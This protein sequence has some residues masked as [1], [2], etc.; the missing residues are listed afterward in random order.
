M[1]S[2]CHRAW[3]LVVCSLC[4]CATTK[5]SPD[6][7]RVDEL[8]LEGPKA[9]KEETITDRIVTNATPW[10][11][12]WFPFVGGTEWF[13]TNTWQAD[14]RRI[15]RLYEAHGYYQARIL[16][17]TVT[18]T[19]KGSVRI[20]VKLTEGAPAKLASLR[21][22]G[23]DGLPDQRARFEAKSPL[24]LGITFLEDDWAKAKSL[25]LENLHEA[26]YA[27]AKVVGEAQVDLDG[28]KVDATLS[29]E[30]GLRYTFGPIYAP[31]IG[32]VVPAKLIIDVAEAELVRG[33][34][35]SESA[36]ANAQA[37]LFQMGVF[38]AVKVNGG[39]PDREHQEL[40]IIIDAREAPLIN[41]RFGGGFGSDLLRSDVHLFGEYVDRNVGFAKLF[42]SGAL[43]DKLT[44]KGRAGY[45]VLPN[46]VDF[47]LKLG[48]KNST[49]RHGPIFDL[50]AQYEVPRVFG[51]KNVSL[52]STLGFNRTLDA[53]FDYYAAEGKL[54]VL[55]RPRVDLTI[56]PS[57]N[58]NAYV[59]NTR[60]TQS[61]T[62]GTPSAAV[63][64]PVLTGAFGFDDLCLV[65]FFD[66]TAEFDRRDNKLEPKQGIYAAASAQL[67]YSKTNRETPFI[68]LVPEVRGY[69]SFGEERWFTLAGKLKAG[70]LV[71]I[72]GGET[73]IVSRFFSGGSSMRG[74]NQ[75][76]LSPMAIVATGTGNLP[77]PDRT[78]F[79]EPLRCVTDA[80]G[81]CVTGTVG[82]TVPVGGNGL[83]EA[84]VEARFDLTDSLVLA[85][86]VDAGMV[87]A[88]PLL[89]GTDFGRDLYVAVGT[90]L[91]YR[92]PLGPIR[93]DVG[94]R[95]PFI[96]GPLPITS[97]E[98][99]ATAP[100]YSGCYFN[101]GNSGST[102]YG[103]APDGLCTIHVSIG[104][105]F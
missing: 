89:V 11:A 64:C 66:V 19:G 29:A 70:T 42:S 26:G 53:A 33:Q 16:D 39:I 95:L 6:A 8:E 35:F 5:P 58:A 104:E 49:L 98:S 61:A 24:K 73:P 87:T 102:S 50:T 92:T 105:A 1:A 100:Y 83:L 62:S 76:R 93:G 56:Y 14:L 55:W 12:R 45:A 44:L 65:G 51:S 28:P 59:L 97:N 54:G 99:S 68:K 84:S 38:S 30:P 4:A 40:P 9:L 67:G 46:V 82:A 71:G 21:V 25:L 13:D 2:L 34:V 78:G 85:F 23:L 32:K 52:V 3:L 43:L 90:G 96:G 103:G 17:E 37:R 69:L 41:T 101:A 81:A 10:Y 88:D 31:V 27:E 18:D 48:N 79:L 63:G 60:I 7:L 74:F 80:S 72:G 22:A 15:T 91:R 86:F 77:S 75:R 57:V 36:L 47:F 94:F 20:K